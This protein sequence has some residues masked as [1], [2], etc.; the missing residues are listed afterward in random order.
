MAGR[1]RRGMEPNA[2]EPGLPGPRARATGARMAV[3]K[4]RGVSREEL[5]QSA[6]LTVAVLLVLGLL[7]AWSVLV[8]GVD[9]WENIVV[10]VLGS[11][12]LTGP[13]AAAFAAWVGVRKRR[14]FAGRR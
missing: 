9:A 4:Q 12:R 3:R 8:P 1:R 5:K 6:A 7:A 2:E 11:L 10:A 13:V 14:A